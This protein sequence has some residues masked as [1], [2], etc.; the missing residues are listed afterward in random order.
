MPSQFNL[1]DAVRGVFAYLDATLAPEVRDGLKNCELRR[2]SP[3]FYEWQAAPKIVVDL[4]TDEFRLMHWGAPIRKALDAYRLYHKTDMANALTC[5]YRLHLR[6]EEPG[7]A[8]NADYSLNKGNIL[9]WLTMEKLRLEHKERPEGSLWSQ[10]GTFHR[11]G[12]RFVKYRRPS[13]SGTLMVRGDRLVWEIEE[14]HCLPAG[15]S[16][17]HKAEVDKFQELG[18]HRAFLAG[19]FDWPPADWI[20]PVTDEEEAASTGK[21][22][23]A[24][25]LPA[26][27]K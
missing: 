13:S 24:N 22:K 10:F 17:K 1:P 23:C 3:S 21:T 12:D 20:N 19:E 16:L 27:A 26:P 8:L 6:R 9:T 18:G 5:A 14:L 4:I 15:R 25:V 2:E 7:E 11:E